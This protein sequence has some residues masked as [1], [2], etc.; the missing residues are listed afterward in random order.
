MEYAERYGTPLYV[1]RL[2]K[3]REAAAALRRALPEPCRLYYSLKANPHPRIVEELAAVGVQ[4]E[5][6]SSGELQAALAAGQAAADILYTGPGK[7]LR[8]MRM[9]IR[10][11]VRRF[12]VESMAERS[13]LADAAADEAKDVDYLVRINAPGAAA[14]G[15][16]LRMTGV[17]SQFGIDFDQ[18]CVPPELFRAAG[19]LRP[20]G[21]HFFPATNVADPAALAREFELSVETAAAVRAKTGFVPSLIDL[22]GGFA[23]PFARPGDLP[24]YSGLRQ[25]LETALDRCF[26]E[27]RHGRPAIA[28]ESGR[29]L[30]AQCGTLLTTVLDVKRSG[31]RT[32]VILDAGTHVLGGMSGLGRIMAPAAVPCTD[33]GRGDGMGEGAC[34]EPAENAT[35]LVG[36]L[37]TPLDVLNRSASLGRPEAG[38][39]L[40]IPNTGAYGLTASLL[41]FLSHPPATEVIVDGADEVHVRRLEVTATQLKGVEE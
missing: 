13:R 25:V 24:D 21:M 32:Y 17:P 3:V 16:G 28:F 22:G 40:R 37:C 8:D 10:A 30:T 12:S 34:S 29:H 41:A 19:R 20:L 23:A 5:I 36:P 7:T 2:E 31:G 1:Y 6:S 26:P 11:G 18:A 27:W 14:G 15:T 35:T 39:L 9:A 38:D 33:A 4:A